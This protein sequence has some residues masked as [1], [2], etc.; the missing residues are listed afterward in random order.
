[1]IDPSDTASR[2]RRIAHP[3]ALQVPPNARGEE[4]EAI[5]TRIPT[6]KNSKLPNVYTERLKVREGF[7]VLSEKISKAGD[8]KG[9]VPVDKRNSVSLTDIQIPAEKRPSNQLPPR[10]G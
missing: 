4:W 9:Q 3:A 1:M 2:A 8:K 7:G 10:A 6:L 5:F